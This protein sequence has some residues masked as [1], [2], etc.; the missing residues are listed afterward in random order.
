[1]HSEYQIH[2]VLEELLKPAHKIRSPN[3][4]FSEVMFPRSSLATMEVFVV[5]KTANT[6]YQNF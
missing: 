4:T 5:Q 6:A 3:F 1:M 2:A